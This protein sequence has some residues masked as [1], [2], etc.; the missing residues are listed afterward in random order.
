[1]GSPEPDSPVFLFIPSL[2]PASLPKAPANGGGGAT[3]RR[4][5]L[6]PSD[7]SHRRPRRRWTGRKFEPNCSEAFAAAK[8]CVGKLRLGSALGPFKTP[9]DDA[10]RRPLH[11]PATGACH[12]KFQQ[13]DKKTSLV[14]AKNILN[15]L[16]PQTSSDA[17]TVGM[18]G[19]IHKR[20][21]GATQNR[22]DLDK[23]VKAYGRGY[24]IKNDYL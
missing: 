12:Y 3:S 7:G 14:N 2:Q 24:Y 1:M 5:S 22:E 19:A 10:A 4:N 20:L 8:R 11:P 21:W 15:A 16:T 23:S 9:E 6:A 18:W 13:P 17:E